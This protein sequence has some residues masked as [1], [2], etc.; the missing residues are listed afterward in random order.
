MKLLHL[1][2]VTPIVFDFYNYDIQKPEFVELFFK[3]TQV[4]LV[5]THFP[6][7]LSDGAN[8]SW[9]EI[10]FTLQNLALFGALLFFLGM[11]NS[12]PKRQSK[13][14]AAPKTKTV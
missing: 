1:A 14:K 13:R 10:T 8:H 3:F 11:K 7:T 4:G 2:V 5:L 12:I 9:I 6:S